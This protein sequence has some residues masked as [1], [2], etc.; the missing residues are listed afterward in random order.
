MKSFL[1][2][3]I[4]LILIEISFCQFDS[5]NLTFYPLHPGDYWEYVREISDFPNPDVNIITDYYSKEVIGDTIMPNGKIYNVIIQKSI[6]DTVSPQFF[7]ER[8]DSLTG[9]VYSYSGYSEAENLIDSLGSVSGDTSKSSRFFPGEEGDIWTACQKV[10]SDTILGYYTILKE[11][12]N[13]T[14]S[15]FA[16]DYLLA[17]DIGLVRLETYEFPRTICQILYAKIHDIEYG[18]PLSVKQKISSPGGFVLYQNFPNPFNPISIIRFELPYSM[19]IEISLYDVLGRKVKTL[20]SGRQIKGIHSIQID[21]IDLSTGVYYYQ[22]RGEGLI[23][24]KKCVDI[25]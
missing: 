23:S 14:N 1:P 11:Y 6:P 9:N 12:F 8:I 7:Y 5:S 22:L 15:Q 19:Q 16:N 24:T 25:K 2:V 21:G 13:M 3:L 10:Y 4:T 17:R 18:I 20:Y